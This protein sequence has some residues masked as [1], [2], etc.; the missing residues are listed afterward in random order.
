MAIQDFISKIQTVLADKTF[1]QL[2]L[3]QLRDKQYPYK[4][5]V[6]KPVEIKRTLMYQLQM[7]TEQQVKH[8]NVSAEQL[9]IQL[10]ALL[11]HTYKQ[12]LLQSQTEDVQLLLSKKGK[13]KIIKHAPTKKEVN[14]QHN[15]SKQYLLEDGK[16]IPFL[17]ELGV[18]NQAGQVVKKKYDKFKQINRFL[19]L[20]H[21]VIP[22]WE[23]Q[24][25]GETL[26]IVD[27][28]CGKSYL[29]FALY[30]YLNE[31]AKINC[32]II[33]LDLKR[34]VIEHCQKLAEACAYDR[35]RFQVGDIAKYKQEHAVPIHMV[36]TLHACDTAT[37]AALVQAIE[38]DCDIILSVPCCQH[39]LN[40]QIKAAPL[41]PLMKHGLLKER[42]AALATDALRAQIL[43]ILGYKT[44]VIEF[45]DLEHTPKNI[46][47]RAFKTKQDKREIDSLVQEYLAYKHFLQIDTYL[48][49][50]CAERLQSFL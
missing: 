38:W 50:A 46:L 16:P 20:V 15:R 47:I 19:E 4:K 2:T 17:I 7:Y 27:F 13:G 33:G 39:E 44:Q 29:T 49:R 25:P 23:K 10:E 26:N 43:S 18:M 5:I 14:V 11:N 31:I 24:H 40:Q 41:Q 8:E 28:G 42:F 37:D 12:G 9:I 34:E 6:I 21:D 32:Q 1:I 30:H 48:E 22:A 45:I 3:S 35:L 36:V